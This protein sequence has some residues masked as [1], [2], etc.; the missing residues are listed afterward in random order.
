MFVSGCSLSGEAFHSQ[1]VPPA[2]S[3][4]YIYQP[5]A[6]F[7]FKDS[8][9]VTCGHES[10][11]V[12]PGSYYSFVE[13]SGTIKCAVADVPNSEIKFEAQ[14]GEEYF[15]KELRESGGASRLTQVRASLAHD[16]IAKCRR[17]GAQADAR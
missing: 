7:T 6:F 17:Q 8:P 5:P 10:I 14:S 3:V 1:A 13:E 11:E 2:K 15:V 16:E 4:I 12:Q 9:M